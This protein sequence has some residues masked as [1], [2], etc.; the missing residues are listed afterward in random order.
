[1]KGLTN[2]SNIGGTVGDDAHPIKIVDNKPVPVSNALMVEPMA[3]AWA[4]ASRD[5]G[6]TSSGTVSYFTYGKLVF[7]TLEVTV[8]NTNTWAN[9]AIGYGLPTPKYGITRIP[10]VVDAYTYNS[11]WLEVNTSGQIY[12]SVRSNSYANLPLRATFMYLKA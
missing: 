9:V 12:L 11:G 4:S 10:V 5:E 2:A 3:S 8:T 1:M 7:V 6:N